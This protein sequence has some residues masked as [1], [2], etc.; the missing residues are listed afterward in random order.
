MKKVT[1]KKVDKVFKLFSLEISDGYLIGPVSSTPCLECIKHWLV[2]RNVK[3]GKQDTASGSL[4]RHVQTLIT[5]RTDRSGNDTIMYEVT[6]DGTF[7]RLD[8]ALFPRVDCSCNTGPTSKP[9]ASKMN[10]AFSPINQLKTARYG[11]PEGNLWAAT[12]SGQDAN[13]KLITASA[14]GPDKNTSRE[15]V[16]GEFLR[17]MFSQ[18]SIVGV[19]DTQEDADYDA[20]KQF[21]FRNTIEAY[22]NQGKSPLL[23]VGCANWLRSKAPFYILQQYDVHLQFYP[24][25]SAVWVVGA[26]A[27]HRTKGDAKPIRV[28]AASSDINDALLQLIGNLV[29]ATPSDS[30]P[31]LL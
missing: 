23:I 16:V 20:L 19:G 4:L 18:G 24:N 12:A 29:I 7:T 31:E 26:V 8:C 25:A 27:I 13:G 17:S 30:E 22:S 14:S 3:V 11:T 21:A 6:H 28:Y 2:S 1:S 15:L 10:V 9:L 5:E